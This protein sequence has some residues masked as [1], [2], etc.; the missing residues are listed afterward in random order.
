ML[1]NDIN[2]NR[3]RVKSIFTQLVDDASGDKDD[4]LPILKALVREKLL[5]EEQYEKLV[6]LEDMD[7]PT[8]SQI[9]SATKVGR[10]LSFLPR[11]VS[12]LRNSLHS[13]LMGIAESGHS[14]IQDKLAAL[15]EEFWRLKAISDEQYTIIK[16]GNDIM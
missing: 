1:V 9:I 13:L 8:I 14:M 6:K 5:S 3:Y 7:L 16:K 12:D 10:V 4:A 11:K 15:L 2:K